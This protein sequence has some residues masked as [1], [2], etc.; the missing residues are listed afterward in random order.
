[1]ERCFLFGLSSNRTVVVGHSEQFAAMLFLSERLFPGNRISYL[2]KHF[3]SSFRA[4]RDTGCHKASD[5]GGMSRGIHIVLGHF[6]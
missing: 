3:P 1:M 6:L 4:D 5:E 2:R